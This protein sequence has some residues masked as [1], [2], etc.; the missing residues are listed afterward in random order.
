MKVPGSGCDSYISGEAEIKIYL[1]RKAP[2]CQY[3]ALVSY[4]SA[5]DR[6][7]CRLTDEWLLNYKKERG[8]KCPFDWKA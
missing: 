6:H 5:F 2:F 3:C 7:Y 1:P 8:E 4:Q